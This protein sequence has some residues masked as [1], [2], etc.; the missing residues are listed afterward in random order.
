[1]KLIFKCD[2][3]AILLTNSE[4][5]MAKDKASD[6]ALE[7]DTPKLKPKRDK[8][9]AR[10]EKIALLKDQPFKDDLPKENLIR[11][12]VKV[13]SGLPWKDRPAELKEEV[14]EELLGRLACGETLIDIVRSNDKFPTYA[15]IFRRVNADKNLGRR[16]QEARTIGYAVMHE[17]LRNLSEQPLRAE[18]VKTIYHPDGR[19]TKEVVCYDNKERTK[20]QIDTI[21][22]QL[23]IWDK[24]TYGAKTES[25]TTGTF[26][27][28][29]DLP[30]NSEKIQ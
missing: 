9:K 3:I 10:K 2:I 8:N 12:A 30:D 22:H 7:L 15:T 11:N 25:L 17:E 4:K 14:L 6:A 29:N 24:S 19:V 26:I 1:M 20:M 5:K 23:G 16:I 27:L 21:K 18:T 28:R 13:K